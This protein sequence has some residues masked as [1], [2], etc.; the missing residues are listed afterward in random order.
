MVIDSDTPYLTRE[1]LLRL[2]LDDADEPGGAAGA[3]SGA[4]DG[5]P[6]SVATE[7]TASTAPTE[8][9]VLPEPSGWSD[10][11]A[12]TEGPR[13][14]ERLLAGEE[15]RLVRYPDRAPVVM[16]VELLGLEELAPWLGRE[17]IVQYFARLSHLL[18]GSV[19]TS[20]H[21]ARIS[22]LRFGILLVE[23]DDVQ[24]LNFV[25]RV[26][27]AFKSEFGSSRTAIRLGIG[28]ASP[29]AGEDLASAVAKAEARLKA[30][31]F[32]TAG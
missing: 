22:R 30:D 23:T 3:S 13:Y 26:L 28:W 8:N 29:A 2:R 12:G 10:D 32:R 4:A 18:A 27:K 25:D 5:S 7:S 17:T 9:A 1:D 24:T 31:F 15:A 21:I 14:W 19:R 20:D 6:D 16:L 11:L